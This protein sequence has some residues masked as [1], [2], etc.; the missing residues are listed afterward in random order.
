MA[1]IHWIVWLVVG[2][3]VAVAS[4]LIGGNLSIFLYIGL[5]FLVVGIFKLIV[6]YITTPKESRAESQEMKREMP[7]PYQQQWHAYKQPA[8]TAVPQQQFVYCARCGNPMRASDYFCS[9]CG[10][11]RQ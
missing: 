8:A 10:T 4:Q 1:G 2:A 3:G 5:L 6:R 7:L 11:R 9:R